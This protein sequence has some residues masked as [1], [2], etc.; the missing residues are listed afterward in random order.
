[1]SRGMCHY[2]GIVLRKLLALRNYARTII[3]KLTKT[4]RLC[5]SHICSGNVADIII[6]IPLG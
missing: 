5:V 6:I 1:M 2:D 3:G 4:N